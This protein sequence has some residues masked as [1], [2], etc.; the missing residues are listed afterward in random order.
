VTAA[1]DVGFRPPKQASKNGRGDEGG[2]RYRVSAPWQASD[3][4]CRDY[5]A[6]QQATEA[7]DGFGNG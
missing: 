2:S 1:A 7:I 3:N 4:R 5:S 6:P